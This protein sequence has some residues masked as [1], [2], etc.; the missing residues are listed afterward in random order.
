MS[1]LAYSSQCLD[2]QTELESCGGC[3][4]GVFAGSSARPVFGQRRS[5]VAPSA[6]SVGTPGVESV[7][8]SSRLLVRFNADPPTFSLQ[9]LGSHA[10]CAGDDVPPRRVRLLL[11]SPLDAASLA[12]ASFC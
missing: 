1:L 9:L 10:V 2:T 11:Q 4:Y 6:G 7:I 8:S 12:G 5:L 3:L